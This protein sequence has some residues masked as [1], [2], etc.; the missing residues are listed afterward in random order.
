M[1]MLLSRRRK[2]ACAAL[3]WDEAQTRY[4][5]GVLAQ[6]KQWLPALPA[7]WARALASRWI[8]ASQGCDAELQ[9]ESALR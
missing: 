3:Q 6:P 8:A 1:G 9:G 7:R 2:G 4:L 5:C